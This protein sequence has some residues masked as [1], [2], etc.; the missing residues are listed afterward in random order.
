[1]KLGTHLLAV[2]WERAWQTGGGE[3]AVDSVEALQPEQA[4]EIC[5]DLDFLPSLSIE[6]IGAVLKRPD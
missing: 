3:Q 4:M 2:L 5:A 1:M 6:R